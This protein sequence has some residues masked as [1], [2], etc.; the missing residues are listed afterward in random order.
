VESVDVP[1][2]DPVPLPPPTDALAQDTLTAETGTVAHP[3]KALD[4]A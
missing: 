3:V 1:L 4:D 2:H